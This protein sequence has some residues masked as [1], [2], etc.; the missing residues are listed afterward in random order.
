[1]GRSFSTDPRHI[2]TILDADLAEMRRAEGIQAAKEDRRRAAGRAALTRGKK[3][4]VKSNPVSAASEASD[5]Q[6]EGLGGFRPGRPLALTSAGPGPTRRARF[7]KSLLPARR[8][9]SGYI[10]NSRSAMQCFCGVGRRQQDA[11]RARS[12]SAR[13]RAVEE[14]M[15]ERAVAFV[16]RWISDNVSSEAFLKDGNDRRPGC[17][18][19]P[20][21]PVDRQ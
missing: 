12:M 9:G 3:Q 13:N 14:S 4:Q 8:C 18:R 21:P 1:M 7:K 2:E 6:L 16:E 5:P 11:G 17:R 15:S 10:R 20:A 19:S